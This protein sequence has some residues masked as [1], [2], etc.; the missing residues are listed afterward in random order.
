[1]EPAGGL[2]LGLN[3]STRR[4]GQGHASFEYLRIEER[5]D[6]VVYVASPGGGP[7]T[8]FALVSWTADEAVFANP[9]H[10]F[11]KRIVYRRLGADGLE[12]RAVGDDD[13][14]PAWT[15]RRVPLPGAPR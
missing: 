4:D 14:G 2:M 9:E 5:A 6:A 12:A 13:R 10:D 7:P 3:R 11:P 8:E 15:F 1:M